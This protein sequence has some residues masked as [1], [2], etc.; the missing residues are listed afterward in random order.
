MDRVRAR[1]RSKLGVLA[2]PEAERVTPGVGGGAEEDSTA[3]AAAALEVSSE[4]SAA[5]AAAASTLQDTSKYKPLQ[6]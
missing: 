5:T 2:S 6:N 4:P 1:D 3:A